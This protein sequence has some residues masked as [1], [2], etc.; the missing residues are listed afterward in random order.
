MARLDRRLPENAPGEFFVDDSCIDCETCRIVAPASF[1]AAP[2]GTAYVHRQPGSPAERHR[3]LMALVSCPTSSIGTT[4]RADVRA[5]SVAFPE[6]V[7]PGVAYCGYASADS[8]GASSWLVLRPEGNV[9]VDSPRAARP[10]LHRVDEL[11]GVRLL[12]LTH[13][14]DVADHARLR[15]HFGCDRVLHADDVTA[16][17]RDVERRIEGR[18]PVALGPE[19]L[20]IPCPGHTRGSAALLFHDVLFTGDHLWGSPD[21]RRLSASRSVCWWSWDEQVGS[22]ERLR[23]FEFRHVLPGHGH[24]FHAGSP[25]EMRRALDELLRRVAARHA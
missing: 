5:A 24:P 13:R 15:R 12:F 14:D 2:R 17:T 7:L 4:P 23:A 10:L 6:P 11:G 1:G 3:G 22:L 9:M 20:A 18:D 8:Y 25:G 19:L 21:G 16:A